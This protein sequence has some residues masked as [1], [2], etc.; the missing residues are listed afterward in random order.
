[1]VARV[2]EDGDILFERDTGFASDIYEVEVSEVDGSIYISMHYV[3]MRKFDENGYYDAGFEAEGLEDS[4]GFDIDDEDYLWIAGYR[5]ASGLYK[6]TSSGDYVDGLADFVPYT[7][8]F[9]GSDYVWAGD[10]A[11]GSSMN[12]AHKISKNVTRELYVNGRLL[13]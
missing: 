10:G 4:D 8:S 1:M 5:W 12:G 13:V 7:A 9:N 2:N 3:N 6:Y 11:V